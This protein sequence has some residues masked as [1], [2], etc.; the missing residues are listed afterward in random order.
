[1]FGNYTRLP[2]KVNKKIEEI[3]KKRKSLSYNELAA[4]EGIEPSLLLRRLRFS[5]PTHFHSA[6]Q[7]R[8]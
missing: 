4:G 3:R 5:K 8:K 1:M 7:P 2:A 6:N